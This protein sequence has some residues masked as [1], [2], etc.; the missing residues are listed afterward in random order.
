[1]KRTL[2][3]LAVLGLI[4]S[5]HAIAQQ[6][7]STTNQ[8]LREYYNANNYN[9]LTYENTCNQALYVVLVTGSGGSWS[10][11]LAPGGSGGPGLSA[12]E[13]RSAGGIHAYACPAGY[14]PVDSNDN[15]IHS[16]TVSQYRCKQ[17]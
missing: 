8:C 2:I 14:V 15:L 10:L 1:V 3:L 13:V 11:D 4:G 17:N 9:W 6:Y 7:T 5:S 16:R 12:N